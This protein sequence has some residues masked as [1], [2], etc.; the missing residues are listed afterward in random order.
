MALEMI[1]NAKSVRDIIDNINK[2]DSVAVLI[3]DQFQELKTAARANNTARITAII[4]TA[5]SGLALSFNATHDAAEISEAILNTNSRLYK[6]SILNNIANNNIVS[7]DIVSLAVAGEAQA[8][9]TLATLLKSTITPL[10]TLE[11]NND[12]YK[13]IKANALSRLQVEATTEIKTMMQNADDAG[14]LQPIINATDKTARIAALQNSISPLNACNKDVDATKKIIGELTSAQE[15]EIYTSSLAQYNYLTIKE[16][17]EKTEYSNITELEGFAI[18]SGEASQLSALDNKTNLAKRPINNAAALPAGKLKEL[19]NLA[20]TK[21]DEL[22]TQHFET[23]MENLRKTATNATTDTELSPVASQAQLNAL[24]A[25][26]DLAPTSKP[27]EL[28]KAMLP[29][30]N[31]FGG[32]TPAY[33]KEAQ[34]NAL[35]KNSAH[36]LGIIYEKKAINAINNIS[37]TQ[38]NHVDSL[39]QLSA[40]PSKDIPSSIHNHPALGSINLSSH[41]KDHTILTETRATNIQQAAQRKLSELRIEK[42]INDINIASPSLSGGKA[43]NALANSKNSE[44]DIKAALRAQEAHFNTTARH[45]EQLTEDTAITLQ[46]KAILKRSEIVKTHLINKINTLPDNTNLNTL[47]AIITNPLASIANPSIANGLSSLNLP[48]I[49][50]QL[51][52]QKDD[53]SKTVLTE[54]DLATIKTTLEEKRS[55]LHYNQAIKPNIE[56]ANLQNKAV[57]NSLAASNATTVSG[58]LSSNAALFPGL[59]ASRIKTKEA[60]EIIELAKKKQNELKIITA[61]DALPKSNASFFT[62]ILKTPVDDPSA[63][64]EALHANATALQHAEN[65]ISLNGRD[66]EDD[67]IITNEAAINIRKAASSQYTTLKIKEK[68][69]ALGEAPQAEQMQALNDIANASGTNPAEKATA[70]RHAINNHHSILLESELHDDLAANLDNEDSIDNNTA[71]QIQTA[72]A[73]QRGQSYSK[74]IIDHINAT[75][76]A[77]YVFFYDILFYQDPTDP[78]EQPRA[79][80]AHNPAEAIKIRQAIQNSLSSTGI[81]LTGHIEDDIVLASD[82]LDKIVEATWQ[83]YSLLGKVNDNIAN[84]SPKGVLDHL[85]RFET[86]HTLLY[87]RAEAAAKGKRD[88][89]LTGIRE[90]L[91]WMKEQLEIAVSYFK[92][93]ITTQEKIIEECDEAIK[94]IT[95]KINDNPDAADINEKKNSL[96]EMQTTK[97]NA[98]TIKDGLSNL[99]IPKATACIQKIEFTLEIFNPNFRDNIARDRGLLA[100]NSNHT[101]ANPVDRIRLGKQ[102]DRVGYFGNAKKIVTSNATNNISL[103][104]AL[105]QEVDAHQNNN[106]LSISG[107]TSPVGIKTSKAF[108]GKN[109]GRIIY[110]QIGAEKNAVNVTMAQRIKHGELTTELF[111]DKNKTQWLGGW[112][113]LGSHTE[114]DYLKLAVE[115]VENHRYANQDQLPMVL[116]GDLSKEVVK[117]AATYA[118]IK[119]KEGLP[120]YELALALN[121]NQINKFNPSEGDEKRVSKLLS[122]QAAKI[123]EGAPALGQR[124]K[125]VQKDAEA[126]LTTKTDMSNIKPYRRS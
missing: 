76:N 27:D 6:T 4:T 121:N 51:T 70:I 2:I 120:G 64:R 47:D 39:D 12:D 34:I 15:D 72:A 1:K 63:I 78:N 95:Q 93:E 96:K 7:A 21:R 117:A 13:E 86:K 122:E 123:F 99:T 18:E 66:K 54:A 11:L 82:A 30:L 100:A 69:A 81:D 83:R 58:I 118:S 67:S 107:V 59:N 57:I 3:D 80:D 41:N 98:K 45:I 49:A 119:R 53:S 109:S 42:T 71:F 74:T 25:I 16:A 84:L 90:E 10:D 9:T 101:F 20:Q 115:M 17:I 32:I 112:F 113:G 22:H 89:E 103:E 102:L 62:N 8:R 50:A 46:N 68:I 37:V 108:D 31:A 77:N 56:K 125:E 79:L 94:T 40:A 73:A 52:A 85:N 28:R 23:H 126:T 33:V 61:I 91:K 87:S 65:D 105:R 92:H 111:I 38:Q 110:T 14:K 29:H 97:Q 44:A 106:P 48:D 88:S 75:T 19:H 116:R 60:D 43:L 26:T 114:V 104:E 124:T 5:S 55:Q 35:H 24:I 36:I